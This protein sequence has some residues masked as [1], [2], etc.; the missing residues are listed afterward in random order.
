L[1]FPVSLI[2]H[3]FRWDRRGD[4]IAVS[5]PTFSASTTI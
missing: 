5:S 3:N 4:G 2:V 1:N